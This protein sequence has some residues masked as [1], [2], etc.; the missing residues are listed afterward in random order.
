MARGIQGSLLPR[1]KNGY[2]LIEQL[3]IVQ[4]QPGPV[5]TAQRRGAIQSGQQLTHARSL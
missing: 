3:T 2:V 1:D 5:T 4:V